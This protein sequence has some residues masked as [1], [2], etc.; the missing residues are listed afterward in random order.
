MVGL[1]GGFLMVPLLRLIYGMDPAVA[2]GTSLVLVFANS[3]SGSIAYLRRKRVDVR[4]GLLIA[5]GAFPTS[6]AGAILVSHVSGLLFDALYAVFL[7]AVGY[8]VIVNRNRRI[9]GRDETQAAN[10]RSLVGWRGVSLGIVVGLVSSL[11]GIGGGVVVVPALLYFSTLSTQAIGATSQFAILLTSPVGV[12]S[13]LLLHDVKALY[14]IPL[15][16]GGLA[17]GQVGAALALRMSG[18]TLMNLLGSALGLAALALV[19]KHL[20]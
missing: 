7:L 17:G 15:V 10:G 3:L 5:A 12:A 11:F 8:D 1:G 14:A 16:A 20:L 19:L 4:A 9:S 2:A 13:H 18:K 6:I